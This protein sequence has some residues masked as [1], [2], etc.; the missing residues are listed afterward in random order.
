MPRVDEPCRR[1]DLF[2]DENADELLDE[3]V[4]IVFTQNMKSMEVY[5]RWVSREYARTFGSLHKGLVDTIFRYN[6][7][8]RKGRYLATLAGTRPVPRRLGA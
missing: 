8:H 6:N 4:R 2:F 3:L 5:Y 1:G 7:R